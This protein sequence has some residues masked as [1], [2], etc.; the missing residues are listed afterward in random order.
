MPWARSANAKLVES[1]G[2][3]VDLDLGWRMTDSALQQH[4]SGQ[5]VLDDERYET[6]SALWETLTA[7][8]IQMPDRD[9]PSS[10]NEVAEELT[11]AVH[12]RLQ[13]MS[14]EMRRDERATIRLTHDY[15]TLIDLDLSWRMVEHTLAAAGRGEI[16]LDR[17]REDALRDNWRELTTELVAILGRH[18]DEV[19]ESPSQEA[20]DNLF[21]FR[22][23]A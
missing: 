21:E 14:D 16:E 23:A 6:L 9:G 12:E 13:K 1:Y 15:E 22:Q 8:I 7:E 11:E 2:S 19:S 17:A 20:L 18:Q 3:I 10:S 4:Q 5:I